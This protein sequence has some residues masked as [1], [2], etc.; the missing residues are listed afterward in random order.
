M[1]SPEPGVRVVWDGL[2]LPLKPP[3][4][5]AAQCHSKVS[6]CS[7]PFRSSLYLIYVPQLWSP[8]LFWVCTLCALPRPPITLRSILSTIYQT[9]TDGQT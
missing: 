9:S 2:L 8:Y 3:G 4:I 5:V 1:Y 7:M 6:N